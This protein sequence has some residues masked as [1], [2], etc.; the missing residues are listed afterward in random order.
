MKELSEIKLALSRLKIID[1]NNDGAY[2]AINRII[3]ENLVQ[4]ALPSKIFEPGI[5]LHRCCNNFDN[6]VFQ[7]VDR[8]SF[9]Q[10]LENIK[11]FGRANEPNQRLDHF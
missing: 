4:I 6:E 7:T 3:K 10:D 8:L 2:T 9:R 1:L 5:R 11:E